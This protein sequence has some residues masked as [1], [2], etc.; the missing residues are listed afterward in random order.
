MPMNLN[1]RVV[2]AK[3]VPWEAG[4]WGIS[5]R[6]SDGYEGSDRVGSKSEA[7]AMVRRLTMGNAS[8]PQSDNV[9]PF[10]QNTAAS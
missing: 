9:V 1:I 6:T 8:P 3:I 2:E 4:E 10:P 7:E 5:Y